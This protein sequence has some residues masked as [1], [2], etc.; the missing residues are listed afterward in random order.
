M[1]MTGASE[2]SKLQ[3]TWPK[4]KKPVIRWYFRSRRRIMKPKNTTSVHDLGRELAAWPFEL[5]T[6][7]G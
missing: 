3:P 6:F 2:L 1:G 7:D 4:G 5:L